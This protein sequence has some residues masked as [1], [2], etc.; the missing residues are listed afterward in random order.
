V[1][2]SGDCALADK[3]T[4]DDVSKLRARAAAEPEGEK[5]EAE[6]SEAKALDAEAFANRNEDDDIGDCRSFRRI[7]RTGVSHEGSNA[8]P[9]TAD[10]AL[11]DKLTLVDVS[12]LRARAAA[13]PEGEKGK[14]EGSEAKALDAE[15]EGER[16]EESMALCRIAKRCGSIRRRSG[17]GFSS[18][19][20]L[21]ASAQ[22]GFN[23]YAAGAG[24]RSL[25]EVLHESACC[26][27]AHQDLK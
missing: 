12:K 10:C 1:T 21:C 26:D 14:A 23:C 19:L 11:A 8:A 9:C 2:G 18:L 24:N 5:G 7:E 16:G 27:R 4:P 25:F 15:P 22:N 17:R 3:L 6:G 13:E 20:E